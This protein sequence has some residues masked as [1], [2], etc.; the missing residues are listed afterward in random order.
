MH[1]SMY[2]SNMTSHFRMATEIW[3][4]YVMMGPMSGNVTLFGPFLNA[5]LTLQP[6][7]L[8][9]ELHYE[10]LIL[11]GGQA[12]PSVPDLIF[13]AIKSCGGRQGSQGGL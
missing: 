13:K 9:L 11:Q 6:L 10:L 5:L 4:M 12:F 3:S 8:V 7:K 2:I 1:V